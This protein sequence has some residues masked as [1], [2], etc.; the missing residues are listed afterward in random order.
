VLTSST[1]KRIH[2]ELQKYIID[3]GG[4]LII[5]GSEKEAVKIFNRGGV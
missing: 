5:Q 3:F 1:S 2:P 4:L